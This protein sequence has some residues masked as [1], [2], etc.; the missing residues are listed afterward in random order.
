MRKG[1]DPGENKHCSTQHNVMMSCIDYAHA[2]HVKHTELRILCAANIDA[3][4]RP[5]KG[6][7]A[8]CIP[9]RAKSSKHKARTILTYITKKAVKGEVAVK[10]HNTF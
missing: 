10:R 2:W 7:K 6:C 3:E 5:Q 1:V 4:A 9:L 8:A